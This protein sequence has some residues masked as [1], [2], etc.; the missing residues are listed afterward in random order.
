MSWW[1]MAAQVG[2][3]ILGGMGQRSQAKA[4]AR[5][6]KAENLVNKA[7]IDAANTIREANNELSV[8]VG[9]LNRFRQNANNRQVLR[10]SGQEQEQIQTNL[11][12]A[13]S[14]LQH[15]ALEERLDTAFDAGALAASAAAA[16][17]GGSS[18]D[19]LNATIRMTGARK[20]EALEKTGDQMTYDALTLLTNTQADAYMQ[21]DSSLILDELDLMPK[22]F[23]PQFEAPAPSIWQTAFG[24]GMEAFASNPQLMQQTA[25]S[26][27][28]TAP[29]RHS[30]QAGRTDFYGSVS[31]RV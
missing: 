16:G 22:Q 5:L 13:I 12:R 20:Q 18:K 9:S 15:G 23:V 7:N 3:Q 24:G 11:L 21:M 29:P 2:M 8:A 25:D 19:V 31:L 14:D 27:R 4:Q 26:F 28:S 10:L 17:V 6:T 30:S 1:A